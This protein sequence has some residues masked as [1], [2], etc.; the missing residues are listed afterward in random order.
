[1]DK[2]VL[3]SILGFFMKPMMV[4]LGVCEQIEQLVRRFIWG[5]TILEPK[6]SFVRWDSYCQPIPKKGIGHRKMILQNESYLMTLAFSFVSKV[7][8]L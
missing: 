2:S 7:D 8:A 3:L 5:S 6:I 1:M 4:P